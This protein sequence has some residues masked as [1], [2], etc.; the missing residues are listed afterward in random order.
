[1]RGMGEKETIAAPD[2]ID[3][4]HFA[5]GMLETAPHQKRAN[6][7][8]TK[9][10]AMNV[11]VAER[12]L[13]HRRD[14]AVP[15]RFRVLKSGLPEEGAESLNISECGVSFETCAP[16]CKGNAVE[17]LLN[18]PEAVT[19]GPVIAWRCVGHVVRTQLI[20]SLQ[21]LLPVGVRFDCYEILHPQLSYAPPPPSPPRHSIG[22]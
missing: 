21:N 13:S 6:P 3:L 1:M 17:I 8:G 22:P 19:G 20:S 15:L 11:Y 4:S 12:R 7:S 9:K 5:D 18:M 16:L 10:A 2:L 14:L